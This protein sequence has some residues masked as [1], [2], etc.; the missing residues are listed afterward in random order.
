MNKIKSDVD[1]LIEE[2]RMRELDDGQVEWRVR[3]FTQICEREIETGVKNVRKRKMLLERLQIMKCL[4]DHSSVTHPSRGG[5]ERGEDGAQRLRRLQNIVRRR[6]MALEMIER[7]D[8]GVV[9]KIRE[10]LEKEFAVAGHTGPVGLPADSARDAELTHSAL[11][12]HQWY[13]LYFNLF[14]LA[15]LIFTLLLVVD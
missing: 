2:T 9:G 14:L 6:R 8:T 13:F 5:G 12:R 4:Y 3:K 1:D 10:G 11:N 7:V 15:F